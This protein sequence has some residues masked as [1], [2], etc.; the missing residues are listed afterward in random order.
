MRSERGQGTVEYIGLVLVVAVLFVGLATAIGWRVPGAEMAR[1][2][3]GKLVCAVQGEGC[4]S[5]TAPLDD[6]YGPALAVLV[7]KHAPGLLFEDEEVASIPTDYRSCRELTCSDVVRTR[8]LERSHAGEPASAFVHVIDCRPG[9]AEAQEG[10]D[11]SGHRA[12]QLY[13]QYWFYYPDSDTRP[14][15][16]NPPG[17]EGYHRDDWESYQ[18]RLGADG[19]VASRASSHH[20][21]NSD[22][23]RI[24]RSINDLGG[25]EVPRWIPRHKRPA[26]T[27]GGIPASDGWGPSTG[28]LWV[29]AGSHAGR[30]GTAGAGVKRRIPGRN[31][32]LISLEALSE[33][34]RD[35]PFDVA[36]PWLK[37]L[38]SDPEEKGTS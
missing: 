11:C 24:S 10:Y 35:A 3:A 14:L 30:S 34:E 20:G 27:D 12:G 22:G 26:P 15:G 21:H 5:A 19:S 8:A 36:P 7:R 17:K 28:R 33:S 29:S 23:G 2:I 6:E 16:I 4:G 25:I 18:V 32:R 38:W 9:R 13:L 31:L 1:T 37:K